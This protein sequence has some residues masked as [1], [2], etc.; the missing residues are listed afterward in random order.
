MEDEDRCDDLFSPLFADN[1]HTI[2]VGQKDCKF[3]L[4]RNRQTSANPKCKDENTIVYAQ[5]TCEMSGEQM[6][7][8]QQHGCIIIFLAFVMCLLYFERL[9]QRA[10]NSKMREK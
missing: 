4:V 8:A 7:L 10:D 6:V 1:F 2:C 3:N 9:T 5:V